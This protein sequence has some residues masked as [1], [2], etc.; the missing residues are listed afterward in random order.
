METKVA[1]TLFYKKYNNYPFLLRDSICLANLGGDFGVIGNEP[2]S[3]SSEGRTYGIEFLAQKKLSK[4]FYGILAYTWVRSEFQ[5]K[6]DE[7]RPSAWDNQ[8]IISLTGGIKLNKD[9]EIGVRFRYSGGPPYTPYDTL[10]SSL[11]YVWDINSFGLFDY[12]RLNGERL[13]A[14]HGL[15]IR[16]DKK[17]YWNKVAL[18][19][20]IDIQ[21]AYNFQGE[22]PPS[23]IAITDNNGNILEDPN[24]PTRYQ[25]KTISNTA[26]T[27]L[28]SVGLQFEF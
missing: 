10:N 3:S 15:D 9:W 24:D 5:D 6:N 4:R 26:G 20:Y 14:N 18:N 17:W 11:K 8:H 7:F 12:N 16:I 22:T 19:V 27:I 28:P 23:L 13:K 1:I 21:N 25:L 2:V